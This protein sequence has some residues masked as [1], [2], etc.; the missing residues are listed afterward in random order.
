MDEDRTNRRDQLADAEQRIRY[1]EE[2]NA[3]AA[4]GGARDEEQADVLAEEALALDDE[5][6]DTG[7]EG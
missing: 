1:E 3:R 6:V 7:G 5:D 4:G 2:S